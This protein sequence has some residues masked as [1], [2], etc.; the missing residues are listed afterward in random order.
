MDKKLELE[1]LRRAYAKHLMAAISCDDRRLERA[2]A[3]TAREEFLGPGPWHA[4]RG[5]GLYAPTPSDD[6]VYLYTDMLFAIVAS[7]GLN[8]GQPSMHAALLR[9]SSIVEGQHV[10]HVGAGTGYYTAI[11]AR[12][13]GPSGRVT[14][15]EFDADLAERA[16]TNLASFQN[17]HVLHANGAEA[18]FDLADVIYVNAGVTR[19]ADPWLERLSDG[20]RLILP[21]TTDASLHSN[22]SGK[23]DVIQMAKRGAVFRI[24][25]RGTDFD[26]RWLFPAA[27]IL[28][29]GV[30]DPESEA[31]LATAFEN[32]DPKEVT[33]LYRT[34]DLPSERCWLR[35]R[36]WCLAYS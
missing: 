21:L 13:V 2:F 25:R 31:A 26:A 17:V 10:V 16:R 15:V 34:A 7:R 19:P 4:L 29:E 27:Y 5:P 24:Q 14:G 6:P 36:D 3:E 32:G 22:S 18:G 23:F 28:A 11:M 8:N 35:G 33:R 1:I 9:A 20:G 30:R 12:L